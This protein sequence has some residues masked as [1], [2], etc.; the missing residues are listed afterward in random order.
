MAQFSN[1]RTRLLLRLRPLLRRLGRLRGSAREIAGGLALGTAISVQPIL[2]KLLLA[3]LLATCWR[4]SRPASLVPVLLVNPMVVPA[5]LTGNYLVGRQLCSGPSLETVAGKLLIFGAG[6]RSGGLGSLTE[7]WQVLLD[8][9]QD[10]LIPLIL[11]SL[12]V[13]TLS[14]TLVHRL[15]L[16]LF[17]ALER[18]RM[19]AFFAP[20]SEGTA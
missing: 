2:G 20:R 14:A 3:P 6:L 12:L 18:R 1:R 10:I 7:A 11:G 15:S 8:L 17:A 9:G 16:M 5:V 13:G 19:R 4:L